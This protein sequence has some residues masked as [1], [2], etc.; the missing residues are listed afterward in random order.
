M[1]A[2]ADRLAARS[3]RKEDENERVRS[4]IDAARNEIK[5]AEAL[6]YGTRDDYKP[7]YA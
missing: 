5:M 1:L 7:L 6:D 4:K 2:V 3:G